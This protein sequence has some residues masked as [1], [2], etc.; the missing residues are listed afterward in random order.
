M[1]F[2]PSKDTILKRGIIDPYTLSPKENEWVVLDEFIY[3]SARFQ[4]QIVIPRWMVT[5]LASIPQ[6]FR[7]LISVNERHRLASL[8]HDYG[9]IFA[10]TT[11]HSRK[12][13]DKILKDFC[14]QQEV[15]WWKTQAIYAAVRAGGW[16]AWRTPAERDFI[17]LE[18]R[19]W[20]VEN[21]PQ[22]VL[23]T[24]ISEFM[25]V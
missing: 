6:I 23:S 8:P 11:E 7:F 12:E 3:W 1:I 22:L 16:W 9:Y 10:E 24:Q 2:D 19:E 15:S 17:P 13:W 21:F 4:K 18:H 14:K 5:D 25:V 20:Y